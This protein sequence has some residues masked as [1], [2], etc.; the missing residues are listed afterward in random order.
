MIKTF[1]GQRCAS[2]QTRSARRSTEQEGRGN[3]MVDFKKLLEDSR[4]KP[5]IS[6]TMLREPNRVKLDTT[7]RTDRRLIPL[8]QS[9]SLALITRLSLAMTRLYSKSSKTPCPNQSAHGIRG[10][11]SGLSLLKGL[12]TRFRPSINA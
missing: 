1:I 4:G 5:A 6:I 12:R 9:L 3:S 8:F 7:S 2:L 10:G 11:R